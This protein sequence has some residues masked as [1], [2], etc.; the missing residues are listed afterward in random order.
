MRQLVLAL[1]ALATVLPAFAQSVPAGGFRTYPGFLDPYA[2]VEAVHD[3]GLMME[4]IVRCSVK[5]D[6]TISP[7]I[8][9][10]SKVER[11][12]CSSRHRCFSDPVRAARD[13]C[14]G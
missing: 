13:T 11:L 9:S 5:A 14:G 3:K 4:L 1:A 2:K 10:Y 12:F 6:G 7:G 8:M